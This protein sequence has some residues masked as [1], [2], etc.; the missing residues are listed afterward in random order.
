M[1]NYKEEALSITQD[2]EHKFE[3]AIE[4]RKL[5]QAKQVLMGEGGLDSLEG[6]AGDDGGSTDLQSKWRRLGKH[7]NVM[8]AVLHIAT[9][10]DAIAY[11][12]SL[13]T[14]DL[15][16]HFGDVSLSEMAARRAGDLSGLL[17]LHTSRGD[18][19][20]LVRVGEEASKGGRFNVAFVAFFLSGLV[21]KALDVLI[22]AKRFV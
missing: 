1:Q 18:R 22:K 9:I 13:I 8:C 2:P 10:V 12:Y 11:L 4:L 14:G 6:E 15:A 16:L 17:L 3:L 21:E 7:Y 5:E 19:E 20:G